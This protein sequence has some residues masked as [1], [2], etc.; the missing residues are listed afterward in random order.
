MTPCMQLSEI[1]GIGFEEDSFLD[2]VPEVAGTVVAGDCIAVVVV[3]DCTAAAAEDCI[4]AVVVDCTA[5]VAAGESFL[6]IVPEVAG[7]VAAEVADTVAA[8]DCTAA[9]AEGCT[10]AEDCIV[11]AEG[12]FLDTALVVAGIPLLVVA[13]GRSLDTVPVD[14]GIPSAVDCLSKCSFSHEFHPSQPSFPVVCT[15]SQQTDCVAYCSD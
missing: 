1:L 7:T 2:T 3:A 5:A 4:A 11:A 14:A 15:N 9:V 6:D 8:V 10:A 13:E 12:G